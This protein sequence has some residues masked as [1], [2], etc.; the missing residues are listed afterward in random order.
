M[1]WIRHFLD[2]HP[3]LSISGLEREA[4]LPARTLHN[5]LNGS[6][7]FPEKH[8]P[9]LEKVLKRYG[10]EPDEA[11]LDRLI[12]E[13]KPHMDKIDPD[14]FMNEVRGRE[15]RPASDPPQDEKEV[16][17]RIGDEYPI[18]VFDLTYKEWVEVGTGK[19]IKPQEW[20]H[21]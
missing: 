3:S 16:L 15:W 13:A 10:Y 8:I 1:N 6:K 11:Y 14:A 17:V 19:V 21:G 9:A 7:G 18:A 2:T 12:E 20:L 5:F 4:G